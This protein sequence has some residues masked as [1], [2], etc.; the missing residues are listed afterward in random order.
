MRPRPRGVKRLMTSA[1]PTCASATTRSSTSRSWLFSALAIADCRH[2]RTSRAMRLRE[3]SRSAS[4]AAT[5]L[6][7]I[8]CASRLSFCGLPRSMRATALASLSARLRSRAFLLILLSLGS[9]GGRRCRA[10]RR[11][12]H[13]RTGGALRLAIGRMAVERARRRE[14]AELVADHLFRHHH[15]NVLL[16]IVDAEGQPDELRQ[17]RRA[18]AP[19]LDHLMPTRGTGLLGLLEQIAVDEWA[20]PNRSR[21]DA[22]LLFLPR[23]AARNDEFGGGLVLAGLLSLGRKTPRRH[24]VAATGGAAFAAAMGMVDRIHRYAAVVRHAAHP[25]LAAGLFCRE[26]HVVVVGDGADRGQA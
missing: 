22:S 20:L 7:R 17:Y 25:A 11:A 9:A 15:R 24:R 26:V 13:G 16:P 18:P 21:H 14:L 8:N 4:A 12:R 19:Y 6:P 1:L 5:F 3:N 2:L 10:R 23:V